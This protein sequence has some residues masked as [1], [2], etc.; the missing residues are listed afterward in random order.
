MSYNYA[1][2]RALPT[3]PSLTQLQKQAKELLKSYRAGGDAAVA[4]VERFERNA[5]AASFALADAQRVL[6]RAYGFSSWAKLK[7]HVDGVNVEAFCAAVDAGDTA[8]VRELANA[9]PDLVNMQRGGAYGEYIAL[10]FAVLNRD[11]EMTRIL[12]K[13]KADA[14][15]GNWPH[16]D[17]TTAYAIAKDRGYDEIVAIIDEEEERRRNELSSPGATISSKTDDIQRAILEGRC[18]EA[19]QILELDL[20]AIGACNL[21]GA[22]PLHIAAWAHEPKMVEWLLERGASVD[23]QD[24]EGKTPLDY[25]A[26]VAGWSSHGR[27]FSFMENS[28]KAPALFD[29]TVRLL[30]S[31]GATLTPR[32]AVAIGD[33]EAVHELH[34]AG[35]LKNEVNSLRGGLLSI[36]ARVNRIDMLSLLLDLGL[37]PDESYT[38]EEGVIWGMPLWFAA[39]AGRHEIAALLLA[40]GADVNAIVNACGDALSIAD[41]TKDEPM[42]SL[43]LKHGARIT[44]ER[45]A[46]SGDTET[47][48]AILDGK[49]PG[50]SLNSENP[51]PADLAAGMLWMA[52]LRG[53][54]EIARLCLPHIELKREDPYWNYVLVHASSPEVL[55]VILEHGVDPDVVARDYTILHHLASQYVKEENRI[56][57]ATLLLDAG[58]SLDKRDQT[59]KSTPLGWACRW[60]RRGLVE[61]YLKRG[62]DPRE[63]E[64][65][66]WARPLAWALKREHSD[67][68]DLLR[69]HGAS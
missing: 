1:P 24:S 43:L 64:A 20:S 36:A 57:F 63:P 15:A 48:Q 6:A 10:H 17:A 26:I 25:A 2:T 14:R 60:G 49:I 42:Q 41:T 53:K 35:R 37:H 23:A 4:E 62:A 21:R 34:R 27:D 19:M 16:R 30:R 38:T 12:M 11:S 29:E 50:Y 66:P 68:V 59:L 22:S 28:R 69:S 8:E 51:S 56:P 3:R 9:R 47:A 7:L 46:G 52:T 44:I 54:V 40:R 65:E 31:K 13:L 32:A 67:I 18:D 55:K 5:S 39:M 61:L 45:V 58:A 33:K